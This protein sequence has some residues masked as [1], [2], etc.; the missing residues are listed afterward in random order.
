MLGLSDSSLRGMFPDNFARQN[1]LPFVLDKQEGKNEPILSTGLPIK[2]DVKPVDT[3]RHLEKCQPFCLRCHFKTH[4]IREYSWEDVSE[5]KKCG[6]TGTYR[7]SWQKPQIVA[8]P[9]VHSARG[10]LKIVSGR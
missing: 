4:C 8:R 2:K 5:G 3:T 6:C 1:G 7:Y 9:C 10:S